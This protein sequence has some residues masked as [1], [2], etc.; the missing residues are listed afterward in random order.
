MNEKV[1]CFRY[2]R[3]KAQIATLIAGKN[4]IQIDGELRH[5]RLSDVLRGILNV[6]VDEHAQK[7][8]PELIKDF[9]RQGIDNEAVK[10]MK[11]FLKNAEELDREIE[12]LPKSVRKAEGLITR[13]EAQ[14]GK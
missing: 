13:K 2:D 3:W 6:W 7:Y 10:Y 12:E 8:F 5:A 1:V 11:E 4:L 14:E 9:E